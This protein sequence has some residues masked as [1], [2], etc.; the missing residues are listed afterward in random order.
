ETVEAYA[1][2]LGKVHE[3]KACPECRVK[4][5]KLAILCERQTAMFRCYSGRYGQDGC[6]ALQTEN[7]IPALEKAMKKYNQAENGSHEYYL[8][9]TQILRVKHMVYDALYHSITFISLGM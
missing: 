3:M 8:W 5:D 7:P 6:C 4:Y 2:A 9:E 1:E